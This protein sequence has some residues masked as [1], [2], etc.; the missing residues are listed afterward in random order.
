[1]PFFT[2]TVLTAFPSS[3]PLSTMTSLR[4]LQFVRLCLTIWAVISNFPSQRAYNS[5]LDN[6]TLAPSCAP[7]HIPCLILWSEP[8]TH[9]SLFSLCGMHASVSVL[10]C[11][12][13]TPR[14]DFRGRSTSVTAINY[15]VVLS[16]RYCHC[17]SGCVLRPSSQYCPY[18]SSKSFCSQLSN[19]VLSFF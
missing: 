9:L 17:V 14:A 19:L 6:A 12:S 2:N 8:A 13:T 11:G 5:L 1:M 18:G 3:T 4:C 15:T 10:F 7:C 16:V